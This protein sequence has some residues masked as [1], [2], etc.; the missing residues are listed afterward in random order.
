MEQISR[1]SVLLAGLV[2]PGMLDASLGKSSAKERTEEPRRFEDVVGFELAEI[3]SKCPMAILP[4]GSLEFHGPHNPLGA[5]S[6]IITGIA[7]NVAAR[8]NGLLFPTIKFTQCPAHTVHFQGTLSVGPEVMTMYYADVLR[9]ILQLGFRKV[10]ILNGH[11]GNIGPGRGAIA[12]VANEVKGAA[13]LFASWWEF[14]S[15]ET[16]NALE[17]FHQNNGGH[18]HGGPL[19]TSAVAA[20]RPDLIHLNKAKDLPQP[21]DL[22]GG[23]PYF[24]QKSVTADWPGYSGH[25]SEASAEKGRKIVQ[26]SEDGIVKLIQNWLR[27]PEAPGSW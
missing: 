15:T 23:A 17:L 21:P 1:R 27:N 7:E 3:V 19:E 8:T 24:L 13:L 6:I 4:L 14:V 10:F 26:I 11:D 25:V 12:Q 18:G 20:F 9:N 2:L 16:M 5:D 22:S